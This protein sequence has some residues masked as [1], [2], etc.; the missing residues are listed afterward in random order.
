MTRIAAASGANGW[1]GGTAH[2]LMASLVMVVLVAL[3]TGDVA[4]QSNGGIS[5][6]TGGSVGGALRLLNKLTT[7]KSA[8]K[9]KS[10]G[11]GSSASSKKKSKP[12]T[13][14]SKGSD[15][16]KKSAKKKGGEAASKTS[17][18]KKSPD[19]SAEKSARSKAKEDTEEAR[20]PEASD[21]GPPATASTG[22]PTKQ[23]NA[24]PAVTATGAVPAAAAPTAAVIS[25]AAEISTAQEHLRYLGYEI[26]AATGVVDLKTKIAIMKYQ[27]SI[28]A[29]TTGELTAG[30]LQR[31]F[32]MAAERSKR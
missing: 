11:T 26:D 31:L 6:G 28:G 14:R 10:G 21:E 2:A 32:K 8:K 9:S 19:A 18:E 5:I 25:T 15:E 20:E 29:P 17:A 4:A 30:Q 27:D 24:A 13:A 23:E 3:S 22:A 12:A 7:G 16:P 1:K